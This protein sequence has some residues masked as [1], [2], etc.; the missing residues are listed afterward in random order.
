V[1]AKVRAVYEER[2][3]DL[4]AESADDAITLYGRLIN[5]VGA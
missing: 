5:P 1:Y 2:F 3:A 4:I